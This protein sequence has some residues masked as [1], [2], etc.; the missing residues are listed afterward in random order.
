MWPRL[1]SSGCLTMTKRQT[2]P[3]A[4]TR[5]LFARIERNLQALEEAGVQLEA[6]IEMSKARRHARAV[7]ER[8][9]LRLVTNQDGDGA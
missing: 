1:R 6:A 4:T 5:E 8:R 3:R 9:H 2:M 7:A